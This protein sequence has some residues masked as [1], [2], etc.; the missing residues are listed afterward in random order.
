MPSYL[1]L[2]APVHIEVD[3]IKRSR[4][5]ADAAPVQSEQE[6]LAFIATVRD[7]FPDAGHHC[8]AWRLQSGDLGFRT[9]D[10]GEPG[11]TGG[12]PI[13]AHIDGAKLRGVVI[14]VTR[15]FGGTKLGKGGLIRAYGGTAGTAIE[16]AEII[17]VI[18]TQP[19]VIEYTYSDQG[20]VEGVLRGLGLQS[21][22][23]VF[24]ANVTHTVA[25]PTEQ[26][27]TL[28]EQLKDTTSGRIQRNSERR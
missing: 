19:V 26:V 28:W 5:F 8:F 13:L 7:R 11:G 16:Q 24:G 14:V 10:D 18:E 1:T 15:Y 3:P 12:P 20:L 21:G 6:A 27:D 9:S 4:F 17:E 23:A 22:N 25:V 2:R